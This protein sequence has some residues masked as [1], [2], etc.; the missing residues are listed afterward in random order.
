[1]P[2]E[3]IGKVAHYFNKIGVADIKLTGKLAVGDKVHFKGH[4]SD[5]TQAVDSI[6]IEHESIQEA[7]PGSSVGISVEGHAHENDVVYKVTD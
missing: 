5:W 2:E 7:G 1:M 6:Q 4:T 3:E